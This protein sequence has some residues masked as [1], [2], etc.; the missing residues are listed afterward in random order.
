M[1]VGEVSMGVGIWTGRTGV[2]EKDWRGDVERE[3]GRL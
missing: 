2:K 3:E 1:G